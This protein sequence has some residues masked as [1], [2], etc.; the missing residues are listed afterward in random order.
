MIIHRIIAFTRQ[1]QYLNNFCE[2]ISMNIFPNEGIFTKVI[3]SC[4]LRILIYLKLSLEGPKPN[5]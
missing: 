1:I 5:E 2:I 4:C 3:R